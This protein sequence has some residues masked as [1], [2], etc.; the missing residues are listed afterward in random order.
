MTCDPSYTERT[1]HFK[2]IIV[3]N[4]AIKNFICFINVE[5]FLLLK[6]I[7]IWIWFFYNNFITNLLIT[8]IS[9]LLQY[10]FFVDCTSISIW[11]GLEDIHQYFSC[12][13]VCRIRTP[14]H[15]R[16]NPKFFR[17]IK[18]Y[19]KFFISRVHIR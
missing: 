12:V 9:Y 6:K 18:C 4:R 17:N 10:Y 2:S 7:V 1:Y 3:F 14:F 13:R 11:S 16:E 5:H 15:T 19:L 8:H